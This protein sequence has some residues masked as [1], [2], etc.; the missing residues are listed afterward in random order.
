VGLREREEYNGKRWEIGWRKRGKGGV[1]A[2]ER[3][4]D[5]DEQ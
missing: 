4:Y 3:G 1:I 2:I 5:S